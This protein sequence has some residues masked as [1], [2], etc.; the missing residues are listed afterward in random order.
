MSADPPCEP[1]RA[2]IEERFSDNPWSD[3]FDSY[4]KAKEAY[5]AIDLQRDW[6][7]EKMRSGRSWRFKQ[8]DAYKELSVCDMGEYG[9]E[10]D[11]E[12]LEFEKYGQ[13]NEPEDEQ[14]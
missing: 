5:D 14:D 8:Y 3:D 6:R 12:V 4:E 10:G 2:A 1:E 9:A 13:E 7:T 11:V